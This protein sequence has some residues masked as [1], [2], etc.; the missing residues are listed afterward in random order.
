MNERLSKRFYLIKMMVGMFIIVV[1]LAKWNMLI[2]SA[3]QGGSKAADMFAMMN[4]LIGL[5]LIFKQPR[6]THYSYGIG[7][8]VIGIGWFL[9]FVFSEWFLRWGA[10]YLFPVLVLFCWGLWNDVK[11]FRESRKNAKVGIGQQNS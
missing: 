4:L 3:A 9:S 7:F 11:D 2:D 8:F 1:L 10:Y 5:M 6:L